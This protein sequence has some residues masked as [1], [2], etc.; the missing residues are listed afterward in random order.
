MVQ[1]ATADSHGLGGWCRGS[2][3]RCCGSR[4]LLGTLP[5]VVPRLATTLGAAGSGF[6]PQLPPPPQ[7]PTCFSCGQPGHFSRECPQKAPA[8]SAP[9]P[10]PSTPAA[11]AVPISR[12]R[13][14][15]VSAEGVE[16]DP[17]VL[18]G[19][20]RINDS[21]A[22]VLFDSGASHSFISI[23]Y[24]LNHQIPFE[25]MDSPL[26]VKTPGASWHTKWVAPE[27]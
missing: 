24:A 22:S 25:D 27:V 21:P 26:V 6:R 2:R 8:T 23:S 5:G 7:R 3:C 12:G 1:P 13:L 19:M 10:A 18:M 20:L 11:K 17:L 9:A 4:C 14:N 15:H 16:R